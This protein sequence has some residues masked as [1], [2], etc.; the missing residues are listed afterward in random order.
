MKVSNRQTGKRSAFKFNSL[1]LFLYFFLLTNIVFGQSKKSI[2]DEIEVKAGVTIESNLPTTLDIKISG[3]MT[4]NNTKDRY[5]IAGKGDQTRININKELEIKTWDKNI[6]KQ[7]TSIIVKAATKEEEI[8]LLD[9][10]QLSLKEK[11]GS[12]VIIDCNLNMERFEMTNGFFKGDQ[13]KIVLKNG[14]SYQI[15]YLEIST[16]LTIPKE[17]NLSVKGDT[18]ST[19]RLGELFGDVD[20]DLQYTEVYG[21]QARKLKG[22][23]RSCYNV[24]FDKLAF[25]DIS[26]SNSY[27]NIKN[28]G[29]ANIGTQSL[30]DSWTLSNLRYN[31]SNS[32]QSK[33]VFGIVGLLLIHESAND[34]IVAD[35][36][37]HIEVSKTN[38]SQFHIKLLN[39]YA[40]INASNSD[41]N[42]DK[43]G[44]DFLELDIKNKLSNINIKVV[45]GTD[46]KLIINRNKYVEADL[47]DILML[48]SGEGSSE[49]IYRIGN[50]TSDRLIQIN[51]EDC[52]LQ[53]K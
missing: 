5:T 39:T 34:E 19:L 31:R 10:L 12:R 17:S 25:A 13:C 30:N 43:V 41:L 44:K 42:I 46:Y 40:K 53:V 28:L 23:L 24:Y 2:I 37:G 1:I 49:E 22:S 26:S 4:S 36:V 51:C 33:Y 8:L 16:K 7:E 15:E 48:E 14:Q 45:E 3:S 20:L 11:A 27:I 52:R 18:N 47:N 6:V 21:K 38:Y 50:N 35:E 29:G 9:I 32:A